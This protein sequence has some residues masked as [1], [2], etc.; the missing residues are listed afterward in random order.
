MVL[1]VDLQRLAPEEKKKTVKNIA[2]LGL[3]M[4]KMLLKTISRVKLKWPF[5]AT[6]PLLILT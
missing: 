1:P 5:S 3:Q 6:M 2:Y 4:L